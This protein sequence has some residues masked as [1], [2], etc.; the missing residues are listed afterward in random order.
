MNTRINIYQNYSTLSAYAAQEI[1]SLVI[2]KP[3]AV[4]CLAAGNTPTL[5]YDLLA[6]KAIEEQVDFSKCVFI[7]LDEWV[8]I[9]PE[10]EGSCH[11]FLRQH[12]FQ[13]LHI[14]PSQIH[15]FDAL[16]GALDQQ[17]K[18]MDAVIASLGGIDLMLVGVGINGH[19]G[20]N[21]P[22]I[23]VDLYAHVVALDTTTQSVGQKYFK[24]NTPLSMGITL[25]LKHLL[26]AKKVILM[27]NGRH[28]AEIIKKALE[29]EINTS[30]PASII[31]THRQALIMLDEDAAGLL[32]QDA[33]DSR[34]V[35]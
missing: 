10:N 33:I 14:Q 22:G 27:A 7:G 30:L 13:T 17:C 15:L 2:K 32:D 23:S 6:Q 20:F 12:L 1:I 9:S 21:E 16:S 11:Y 19:I 5:A 18:A 8:G 25:G 3:E 28:K 29:E 26:E 35:P 34:E 24:Q 31:R 4:L